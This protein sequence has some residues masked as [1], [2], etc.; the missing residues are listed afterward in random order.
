MYQIAPVDVAG[1]GNDAVTAVAAREAAAHGCMCVAAWVRRQC[2]CKGV[3]GEDF[4]L[5]T[6]GAEISCA[7]VWVVM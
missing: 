7:A 6:A 3:A 2:R 4:N 1:T 5:W